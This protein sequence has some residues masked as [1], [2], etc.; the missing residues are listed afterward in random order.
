[1]KSGIDILAVLVNTLDYTVIWNLACQTIN[2]EIR[3]VLKAN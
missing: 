1:M 2:I 3:F